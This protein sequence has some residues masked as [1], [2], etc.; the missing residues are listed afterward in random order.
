MVVKFFPNEAANL[1]PVVD[2]LLKLEDQVMQPSDLHAITTR[3]RFACWQ[4]Q[5]SEKSGSE[6]CLTRLPAQLSIVFWV[7]CYLVTRTAIGHCTASHPC[8]QPK[9]LFITMTFRTSA[10]PFTSGLQLA[11]F[12]VSI[13]TAAS[14]TSLKLEGRTTFRC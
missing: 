13:A 6:V 8:Q 4:C 7:E 14:K 11:V 1:E 5:I 3:I 12:I 9:P 10:W 2:M